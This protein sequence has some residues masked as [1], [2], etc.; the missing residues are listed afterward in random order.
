[1]DQEL[2]RLGWS[3]SCLARRS[4]AVGSSSAAEE[5]ELE[6]ELPFGVVADA[7]DAYVAGLLPALEELGPE[8]L[9]QMAAVLPSVTPSGGSA[10]TVQEERYRAYRAV[11]VLLERLAF[12][13]PM[14]LALDDL[15]WADPAS[16]ELISYLVRHPH[17]ASSFRLAFRTHPAPA[18]LTWGLGK[19]T[20]EGAVQRI[21]LADAADRI[22]GENVDRIEREALYRDSGSNPLYP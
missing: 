8:A 17:R 22:I 4:G 9:A 5:G 10:T 7:L 20:R 12:R 13:R 2:E 1:M 19:A 6:L 21:D 3:P 11:R 15:H 14:V 18:R 16:I